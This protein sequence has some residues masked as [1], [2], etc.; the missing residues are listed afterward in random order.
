M[1]DHCGMARNEAGLKKALAEIP[2]LREEFWKNVSVPG[3]NEELNQRS[4]APAASPTSWSSA[5]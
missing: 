1:W 4:R 3:A 2:A 5:S